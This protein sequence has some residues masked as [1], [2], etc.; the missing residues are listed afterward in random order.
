MRLVKYFHLN[1]SAW[2]WLVTAAGMCHWKYLF[3]VW[4]RKNPFSEKVSETLSV[5]ESIRFSD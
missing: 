1:K 3:L 4:T 5:L 2:C